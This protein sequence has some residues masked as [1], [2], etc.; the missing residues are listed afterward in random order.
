MTQNQVLNEIVPSFKSESKRLIKLFIPIILGQLAQTAMSVADTIMAGWAGVADLSGVAI[1]GSFFWPALFFLIGL[2]FAIQP[3]LSQLRGK[4][5]FKSIDKTI[6]TA[7]I[8]CI[9]T[10]LFIG[11]FIYFSPLIYNFVDDVDENMIL[12]AKGYLHAVALGAPGFALFNVLRSYSEGMGNTVPTFIF[13]FIALILNIPLNYIFIFGK[14]GIPAF[15]GVGCGIATTITVYI[16]CILFFIYIQKAK[17]YK[18]IR[19]LRHFHKISFKDIKEYL[20]IALP[21]GLSATIEVSCFSL[22]A[23]LLS[24]FGKEIV[25][26]HSIALTLSGLLYVVPMSFATCSTIRVG[27]AMGALHWN[28]ALRTVK[29]S[30]IIGFIIYITLFVT[31][32]I[33]KDNIISL[34]TK[35]DEV[36]AIASV[37]ILL[38]CTYMLPDTIQVISIGILRGF[39][40]SRTIF[41]VTILS[42]WIIAMP[43]GYSLAYGLILD[44]PLKASGFWI[45]FIFGL[46]TATLVYT[47]RLYFLFKYKKLPKIMMKA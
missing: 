16:T 32:L 46:S 15:G 26:A 28:R 22:V 25:G 23:F 39:K 36:K 30:F 11:V 5:D 29:T 7:F 1:G 31:V 3:T 34:F 10:S 12:I 13:G 6:F 37:L 35:D 38:C 41:M 43:V 24:P 8:V 2:S 21:L 44:E 4:N 47:A 42:Y 45:G 19:I 9:A 20:H 14:F 27:E 33:F 18:N 40:D 17:F